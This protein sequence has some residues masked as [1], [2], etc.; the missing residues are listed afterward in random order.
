MIN[1]QKGN[2]MAEMKYKD[3]VMLF[4]Q[5]NRLHKKLAERRAANTDIQPSQ[6]RMLMYLSKAEVA[7]SQ[8]EIAKRFE[9]SPAAVTVTLKKL[10]KMGYIEKNRSADDGDGRVNAI[11]ITEKGILEAN[12]TR[13]YFS[14]IDKAMFN[15]FTEEEMN[16]FTRLLH[17]VCLNLQQ[18]DKSQE[19]K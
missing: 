16:E 18:V 19:D 15:D 2:E 14:F 7:P 1:F 17:K 10:E 6:H 9:I 12:A 5:T 4:L 3:L 11:K 8:C 13:E